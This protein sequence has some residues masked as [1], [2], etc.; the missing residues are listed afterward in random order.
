M[1]ILLFLLWANDTM[2]PALT[3]DNG[4]FFDSEETL[5]L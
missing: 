2:D 1:F 3:R 5:A 4:P